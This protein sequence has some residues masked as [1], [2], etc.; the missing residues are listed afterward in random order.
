MTSFTMFSETGVVGVVCAIAMLGV[1][2]LAAERMVG[3][4]KSFWLTVLGV[5]A[6][7]ACV[8]NWECIQPA[9]LLFGLLAAHSA[10]TRHEGV[11]KVEQEHQQTYYVALVG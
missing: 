2:F 8:L 7:G 9:W 6:I 4:T 10:C 1:L 5:W 3:I 11:T